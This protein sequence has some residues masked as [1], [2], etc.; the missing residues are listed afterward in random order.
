MFAEL[1]ATNPDGLRYA[2][3]RLGDGTFVHI[4]EVEGEGNPLNEIGAFAAFLDG[5]ADRCEPGLGPNPQPA[6]VVGAYGVSR[7][8][9]RGRGRGSRRSAALEA[10]APSPSTA[11]PRS[12]RPRA[13]RSAATARSRSGASIAARHI[14]IV[15]AARR[16]LGTRGRSIEP[17]EHEVHVAARGRAHQ[18]FGHRDRPVDAKVR[19]RVARAREAR[20]LA[21]AERAVER[22]RPFEV[23]ARDR[24]ERQADVVLSTSSIATPSGSLTNTMRI[25]AAVG[26]RVNSA[27]RPNR[28]A[29]RASRSSWPRRDRVPECR[30]AGNRLRAARSARF[31]WPEVP[32]IRG[33]RSRR[34]RNPGRPRESTRP[35][36]RGP[37]RTRRPTA[38]LRATCARPRRDRNRRRRT[39]RERVEVGAVDVDVEDPGAVEHAR[40]T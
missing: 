18:D 29:V 15:F 16:V 17:G 22:D 34:R 14:P 36:G 21:E 31:R 13:A 37:T 12:A 10:R 40:R 33:D 5:V 32:A 20:Q 3:L 38:S 24:H 23:G 2:T 26:E 19:A 1:A 8:A 9:P 35:S 28:A 25:C 30:S 4:A 27:V 39:A 7:V 11:D 6:T